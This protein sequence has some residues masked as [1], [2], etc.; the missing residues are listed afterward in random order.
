M[1][2]ACLSKKKKN[3]LR[4][5]VKGGGE[6]KNI[7]EMCMQ[8]VSGTCGK[9][10]REGGVGGRFWGLRHVSSPFL[11]ARQPLHLVFHVREGAGGVW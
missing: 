5:V 10:G 4:L 1:S 11:W 6:R 3:Y 2:Q 9:G 7:P 8:H